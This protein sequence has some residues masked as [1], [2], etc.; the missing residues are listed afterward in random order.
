MSS[1]M[2]PLGIKYYNRECP[3]SPNLW[4]LL[5]PLLCQEHSTAL[6]TSSQ[7]KLKN[8]LEI[9]NQN[10][11]SFLISDRLRG[12]FKQNICVCILLSHSSCE[13]RGNLGRDA[14]FTHNQFQTAIL[15]SLKT[16]VGWAEKSSSG[17]DN[18]NFSLWLLS[19]EW[20][21]GTGNT[22]NNSG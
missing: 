9:L 2:L 16:K 8:G 21:T 7:T 22:F 13:D 4:Q 14:S 1:L 12:G 10:P 3:F 18:T 20:I 5:L 11:F 6:G 15:F 17:S 19:G